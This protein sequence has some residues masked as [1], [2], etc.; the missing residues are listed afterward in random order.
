M[1]CRTVVIFVF[2]RC[3]KINA[4]VEG[5][6]PLTFAPYGINGWPC[7]PG[8]LQNCCDE[9]LRVVEAR[10]RCLRENEEIGGEEGEVALRH[11]M[12]MCQWIALLEP[13]IPEADLLLESL[14]LVANAV[15]DEIEQ[16]QLRRKGRPCISISEEQICFFFEH[17]F[18]IVDIAKLFGC[19]RRTVERRMQE[20]NI[21]MQ[22]RYSLISDADLRQVVATLSSRN[23]NLGEKSI[24]GL[25]RAQGI[26][27]QRHRIRDILHVVDPEG[28]QHRLRGVL[29]RRQYSVE[30]PNALWH[31][32]GYHKLIRWKFV[33]H[34]G[35]DGFSRVITYMK[36]ATN[37]SSQTAL[38]AFL[39]GVSSYGLP[40]RVRTDQGGENVLIAEYMLRE[41][42]TGRGSIIMGR[43]VHNQRIER[44]WRDLFAGCVS[45]FYNLF[46]YLEGEAS[47]DPNDNADL[48]ALHITF[49]P[50]LQDQLDSF[51]LGWCH[52]RLRTEHNVTPHH[53][54][55]QGML[56]EDPESMLVDGL[57][58]R[59]VSC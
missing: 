29:H 57:S 18:K 32:D 35:I 43:S 11:S 38:S 41:R 59:E 28:V 20:Y 51:R 58:A 49:L 37:N 26:I 4:N 15:A 42:G 52:H 34:G 54:W 10:L 21:S 19:S 48:L 8:G 56:Q 5:S 6:S 53:L 3:A 14:V 27:V 7:R 16:R 12:Q 17:D 55:L 39:Y 50:K 40:S 36:A 45:Y 2:Y 22:S 1:D 44:L 9:V 24:D 30:A 25:L 33:V 13:F 23:P 47:L 31:V 46:Y